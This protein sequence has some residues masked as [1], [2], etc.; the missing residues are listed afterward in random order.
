MT[1]GY[2]VRSVRKKLFIGRG[3]NN[4][5]YRKR[6]LEYDAYRWDGDFT[7]KY[8]KWL[9]E[10]LANEL[11]LDRGDHLIMNTFDNSCVVGPG[12]YILRGP[13]SELV[14]VTQEELD[15]SYVPTGEDYCLDVK[16]LKRLLSFI[17]D[18]AMTNIS[19]LKGN[20]LSVELFLSWESS[21][22]RTMSL[23]DMIGG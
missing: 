3:G 18:D 20:K 13:Q 15:A 21:K 11:V 19:G 9:D 16:A 14:T 4:M 17:P 6:L 1:T 22:G 5:R 10:A 23:D 8:P 12:D 2:Y 7:A